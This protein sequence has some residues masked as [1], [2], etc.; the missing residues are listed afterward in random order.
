MMDR[1][2]IPESEAPGDLMAGEATGYEQ[3]K[4]EQPGE[5]H[6]RWQALLRQSSETGKVTRRLEPM[7]G[8]GT[9]GFCKASH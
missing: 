1:A 6:G 5:E 4:R 2:G 3:V 7:S 9:T 8:S